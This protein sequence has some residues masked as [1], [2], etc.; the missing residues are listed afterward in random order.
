MC[1]VVRIS[2]SWTWLTVV[3]L[4]LLLL[5]LLLL[6]T[7][8]SASAVMSPSDAQGAAHAAK[9]ASQKNYG[10]VWLQLRELA[11]FYAERCGQLLI[12][13]S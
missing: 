5:L 6:I 7:A 3:V 1:F 10:F 9:A 11:G 4:G 12:I 2:R 8:G 13:W